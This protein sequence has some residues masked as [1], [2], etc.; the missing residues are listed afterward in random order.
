MAITNWL[1]GQYTGD[2]Y[3]DARITASHAGSLTAASACT[4][5]V[6]GS[7]VSAIGIGTS[8]INIWVS[9]TD[10]QLTAGSVI[11]NGGTASQKFHYQIVH[12]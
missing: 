5:T 7:V 8:D 2:P 11:F 1:I 6:G 3:K 9:S 4:V 10:D 12:K